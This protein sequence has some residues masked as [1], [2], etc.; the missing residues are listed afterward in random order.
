MD[1][2]LRA[3]VATECQP[4]LL[5]YKPSQARVG[6]LQLLNI[7]KMKPNIIEMNLWVAAELHRLY[8]DYY[9]TM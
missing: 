8:V 6:E 2:S 5:A 3:T 1:L 7:I 4:D 9:V